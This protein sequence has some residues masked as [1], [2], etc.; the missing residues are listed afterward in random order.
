MPLLDWIVGFAMCASV[1]LGIHF[2]F[3]WLNS[4]KLWNEAMSLACFVWVLNFRFRHPALI[5]SAMALFAAG[6]FKALDSTRYNA[7]ARA[8]AAAVAAVLWIQF[9]LYQLVSLIFYCCSGCVFWA[10]R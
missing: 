8:A 5:P 6:T 7:W 3:K 2:G 9:G 1:W 4:R 10:G